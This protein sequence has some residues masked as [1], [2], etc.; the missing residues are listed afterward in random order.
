M[1]FD[2]L[3][4]ETELYRLQLSTFSVGSLA[5]SSVQWIIKQRYLILKRRPHPQTVYTLTV[6]G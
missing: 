6:T 4:Y 2:S 5:A 3:K 1:K